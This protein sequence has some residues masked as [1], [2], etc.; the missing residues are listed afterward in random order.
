MKYITVFAAVIITPKMR[1]FFIGIH[2]KLDGVESN[3]DNDGM[4]FS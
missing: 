1:M 2:V 4:H 3:Q